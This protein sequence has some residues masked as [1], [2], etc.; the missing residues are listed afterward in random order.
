MGIRVTLPS[1]S[2]LTRREAQVLCRLLAGCTTRQI[3]IEYGIGHQTVK[4]YVTVIYEKLGIT[5]RHQLV[6][7]GTEFLVPSLSTERPEP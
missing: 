2:T 7:F 4:N 6:T 1:H 5:G 3:A